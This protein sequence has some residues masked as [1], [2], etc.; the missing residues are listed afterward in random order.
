M[1]A[2]PLRVAHDAPSIE[3]GNRFR[4]EV[5]V[6]PPNETGERDIS[7]LDLTYA[8]DMSADGRTLLLNEDGE[9]GGPRRSVYLRHTYGSPPVRLGEGLGRALYAHRGRGGLGTDQA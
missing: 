1:R 7:W 4:R 6:L 2:P 5:R 3:E 9:G 8:L